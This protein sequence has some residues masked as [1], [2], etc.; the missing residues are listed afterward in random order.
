MGALGAACWRIT[1]GVGGRCSRRGAWAEPRG[2]C[3]GAGLA[4]CT[5]FCASQSMSVRGSGLSASVEMRAGASLTRGS[6]NP[7]VGSLLRS[8]SESSSVWRRLSTGTPSAW[9]PR[10]ASLRAFC[11]AASSTCSG[12]AL[13]EPECTAMRRARSRHSSMALSASRSTCFSASY[14]GTLRAPWPSSTCAVSPC[15]SSIARTTWPVEVRAPCRWATRWAWASRAR[16]SGA[17]ST[18]RAGS[19]RLPKYCASAHQVQFPAALCP[20]PR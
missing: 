2:S 10:C 6:R 19:S 13:R 9:S 18:M 5:R 11:T 3:D 4:V 12:R 8:P 1:R 17:S 16:T 7:A 14:S 20:T 15:D